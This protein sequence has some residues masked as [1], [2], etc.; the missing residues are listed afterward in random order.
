MKRKIYSLLLM[1]VILSVVL[2]ISN[3]SLPKR[4]KPFNIILI[5]LDTVRYDALGYTGNASAQTPN[6]DALSK[7]GMIFTGAISTNS[8][9][10][11]AHSSLFTGRYPTAHGIH[12]NGIYALPESEYTL[13]EFLKEHGFITAGFASAFPVSHRFGLSQGFDYYNDRI[14]LPEQEQKAK[15]RMGAFAQRSA[16]DLANAV[17]SWIKEDLPRKKPFFSLY[18]FF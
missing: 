10:T 1:V 13:A 4:D 9:T 3:C 18:T 8:L 16:E 7:Q 14:S 15:F 17:I 11:P 2:S 5:S 6:I 12:T